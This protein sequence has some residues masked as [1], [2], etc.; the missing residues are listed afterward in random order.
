[1]KS[2]KSVKRS[3][4]VRCAEDAT[5]DARQGSS[6][7]TN[8]NNTLIPGVKEET[9]LRQQHCI[10]LHWTWTWSRGSRNESASSI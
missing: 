6:H 3:G 7:L 1:M 5:E 10:A 2:V 4:E 8:N 9:E